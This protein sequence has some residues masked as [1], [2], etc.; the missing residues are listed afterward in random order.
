MVRICHYLYGNRPSTVVLLK[1]GVF[2]RFVACS[3]Y[4]YL[5]GWSLSVDTSSNSSDF[6][7]K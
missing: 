5:E 4:A 7:E 6:E 2:W 3:G 1:V